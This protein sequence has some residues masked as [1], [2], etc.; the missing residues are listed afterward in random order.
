MSSRQ[1]E[2]KTSASQ[3][4]KLESAIAEDALPQDS[5]AAGATAPDTISLPQSVSF[6]EPESPDVII[7]EYVSGDQGMC[8]LF[9]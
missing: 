9:V 1:T 8:L 4:D 2:R 5:T 3:S 7:E 6:P